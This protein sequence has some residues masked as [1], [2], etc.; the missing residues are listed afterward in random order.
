MSTNL[1]PRDICISSVISLRV[2]PLF[3]ETLGQPGR[4]LLTA[5]QQVVVA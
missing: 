1:F 3:K 4:D 5:P 2:N